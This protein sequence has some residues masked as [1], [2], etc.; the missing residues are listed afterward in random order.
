MPPN[1]QIIEG[2][3]SSLSVVLLKNPF[4]FRNH[5]FSLGYVPQNI[6]ITRHKTRQRTTSREQYTDKNDREASW[7]KDGSSSATYHRK[8][9]AADCNRYKMKKNHTVLQGN[10]CEGETFLQ[11]YPHFFF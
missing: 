5:F 2:R 1:S 6:K 11:R 8:E 7:E 10:N 9:K 4:N 3:D